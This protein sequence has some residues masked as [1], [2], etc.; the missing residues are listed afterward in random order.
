MPRALSLMLVV[1]LVLRGLLGDA[2]AMG[3]S[4]APV[5]GAAPMAL[6][7]GATGHAPRPAQA[8]EQGGAPADAAAPACTAGEGADAGACS[9]A[10]GLACSACGICHSTLFTTALLVPPQPLPR[11]ALHP[12]RRTPFASAAV[13]RA[14]KPPIS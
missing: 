5:A 12:L 3:I 11:V 14:T 10:A 1:L 6:A 2:M 4:A 8:H 13:A 9:H 7:H